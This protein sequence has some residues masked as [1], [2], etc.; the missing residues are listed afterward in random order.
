MRL[1][2]DER[3]GI[4]GAMQERRQKLIDETNRMSVSN[5]NLPFSYVFRCHSTEKWYRIFSRISDIQYQ[6]PGV[7]SNINRYWLFNQGVDIEH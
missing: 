1:T 7:K 2:E 4:V 6:P 5:K 3:V